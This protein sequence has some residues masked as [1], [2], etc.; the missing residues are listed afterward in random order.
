METSENALAGLSEAGREIV[1]RRSRELFQ[2]QRQ[3]VLRRNDRLFAGLLGFEWVAA[4]LTGLYISPRTWMGPGYQGRTPWLIA[5]ELGGAIACV[6]ILLA[7]TRPGQALTRHMIAVGQMLMSALL[8][9]L[10]GGQTERLAQFADG[11]ARRR[12]ERAHLLQRDH[13]A[14]PYVR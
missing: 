14:S 12:H 1:D 13:C 9:H 5:L 11:D 3:R 8:I 7:L 2:R 6:P 4:L 10:A